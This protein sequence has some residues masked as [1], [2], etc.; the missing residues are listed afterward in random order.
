LGLVK[1]ISN[2]DLIGTNVGLAY[3]SG[4]IFQFFRSVFKNQFSFTDYLYLI[5]IEKKAGFSLF[6]SGFTIVLPVTKP[7]FACYCFSLII[8][9]EILKQNKQT[10][11]LFAFSVFVFI[12]NLP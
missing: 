4:R 11:L 12:I 8:L 1:G 9:N 5:Y 3:F 6:Y 7:G 2:L 10:S